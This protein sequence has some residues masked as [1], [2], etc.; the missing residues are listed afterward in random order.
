MLQHMSRQDERISITAADYVI[1]FIP[2]I[3]KNR[4]RLNTFLYSSFYQYGF[5]KYH[6]TEICVFS[7]KEVINY[8]RKLNTPVFT[9][10]IDIKSAFD[11]Q[12][13][14]PFCEVS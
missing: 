5:K 6:S 4:C 9:C 2:I 10:F 3:A 11:S 7:L 1:Y 14:P 12:L 13:L 8:Y